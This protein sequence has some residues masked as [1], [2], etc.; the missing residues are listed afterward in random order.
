MPSMLHQI[1]GQ[2]GMT[3]GAPGRR[4]AT[5][6]GRRG[7]SRSSLVVFEPP[8]GFTSTT[9]VGINNSGQVAVGCDDGVLLWERGTYTYLGAGTPTAINGGGRVLGLTSGGVTVFRKGHRPQPL[10]INMIPAG[11]NDEGSISGYA[12][13][14]GSG[15]ASHALLW[16]DGRLATLA[17]SPHLS[18]RIGARAL[19]MNNRGEVV[20]T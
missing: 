5:N 18:V 15:C 13:P 1:L 8:A 19:G 7:P 12:R 16:Q 17:P 14:H 9:A 20:G 6:G 4:G 3:R 10:N 11:F 2:Y